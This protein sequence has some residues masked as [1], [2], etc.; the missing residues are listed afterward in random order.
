[1]STISSEQPPKAI[2]LFEKT[3]V[4]IFALIVLNLAPDLGDA[5]TEFTQGGGHETTIGLAIVGGLVVLQGWLVL[6]ITRS[7]RTW[8][9]WVLCLLL[10]VGIANSIRHPELLE[11]TG[12]FYAAAYWLQLVLQGFSTYLLFK[13]PVVEWLRA[14][15]TVPQ[16][17]DDSPGRP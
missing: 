15:R 7:R 1:M 3:W 2:Q 4:L 12:P 6:S 17:L 13:P 8:A 9:K 16:S 5:F 14:A 11:G 10:W